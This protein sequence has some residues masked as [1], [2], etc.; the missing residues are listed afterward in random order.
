MPRRQR[1]AGEVRRVAVQDAVG[2]RGQGTAQQDHRIGLVAVGKVD[3]R[4]AIVAQEDCLAIARMAGGD[5][6]RETSR[7][8][9]VFPRKRPSM[10]S[11]RPIGL[12]QFG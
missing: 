5:F 3:R 10:G 8:G 4:G 6:R 1:L 11:Q 2:R 12:R 9:E 7:A